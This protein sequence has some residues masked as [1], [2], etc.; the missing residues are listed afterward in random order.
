MGRRKV[1]LSPEYEAMLRD[2]FGMTR[3]SRAEIAGEPPARRRGAPVVAAADPALA[4]AEEE[5]IRAFE[6]VEQSG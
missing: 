1:A 5:A 2:V 4:R 3:G 6:M